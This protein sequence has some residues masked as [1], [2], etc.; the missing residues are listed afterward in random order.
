VHSQLQANWGVAHSFQ[1]NMQQQKCCCFAFFSVQ[2][3]SNKTINFKLL[4]FVSK[5]KKCSCFK[6]K[7]S[8]DFPT[9]QLPHLKMQPLSRILLVQ[10]CPKSILKDS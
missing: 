2:E 4:I 8:G 10:I 9:M 6:S 7:L 5:F 3:K 1:T